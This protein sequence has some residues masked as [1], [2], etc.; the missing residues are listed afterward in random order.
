MDSSEAVWC[1]NCV[2]LSPRPVILVEKSVTLL[3][4]TGLYIVDCHILSEVW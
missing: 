2:S 3:I 1:N 4:Y